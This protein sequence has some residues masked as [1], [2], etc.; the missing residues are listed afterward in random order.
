MFSTPFFGV[1]VQGR[2]AGHLGK[3]SGRLCTR[4][5][6]MLINDRRCK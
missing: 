5:D 2:L 3:S 6:Q 4:D 1:V